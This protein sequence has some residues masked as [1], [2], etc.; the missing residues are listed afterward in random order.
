MSTERS[1]RYFLLEWAITVLKLIK[2][3]P[4][5]TICDHGVT[6]G[7]PILR[8]FPGSHLPA[9]P[10]NAHNESYDHDDRPEPEDIYLRELQDLQG[11]KGHHIGRFLHPQFDLAVIS[12]PVEAEGQVLGENGIV[13]IDGAVIAKVEIGT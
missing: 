1:C 2:I 3:P 12:Y 13:D 11:D 7:P 9:A 10:Y 5:N 4:I 8:R 6:P